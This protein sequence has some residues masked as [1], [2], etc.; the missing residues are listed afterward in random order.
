MPCEGARTSNTGPS[1][2]PLTSTREVCQC[3]ADGDEG[4]CLGEREVSGLVF[5][6]VAVFVLVDEVV[7][8]FGRLCASYRWSW[9]PFKVVLRRGTRGTGGYASCTLCCNLQHRAL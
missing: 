5:V 6:V 7:G 4:M 9:C 8:C 2:G 1:T 3:V